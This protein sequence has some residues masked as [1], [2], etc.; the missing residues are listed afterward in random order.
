EALRELD[1][2]LN[3]LTGTIPTCIGNMVALE[4][5][6]I[7]QINVDLEG[8]LPE[9]LGD[10]V[11][12]KELQLP[13]HTFTGPIPASLGNL[14][15]LEILV[16]GG[17]QGQAGNQLE[18]PIPA[19]LSQLSNLQTLNL[20][21]NRLT[22]P[23]PT[24]L[25]NLA[26]LT[27]LWLGS[28]DLSGTIPAVLGNLPLERLNLAGNELTA[29][30]EG[31]YQGW[32]NLET[33]LLNANVLTNLPSLSGAALTFA[34][35]SYNQ[36]TFGDLEPLAGLVGQGSL[37]Y[38]PQYS[39]PL[40]QTTENGT[41]VLHHDAGGSDATTYDW[42]RRD[43][44]GSG[45]FM[46]IEG[47]T[48]PSYVVI[49][50]GEYVSNARN[51]A[52]PDLTVSGSAI[53]VEI[54]GCQQESLCVNIAEDVG[55][56][57][58]NGVP[59]L[60]DDGVCDLDP[61]TV[62]TQCSLRAALQLAK[63]SSSGKTPP[64]PVS[65]SF[66]IP[67]GLDVPTIRLTAP[68]PAIRQP[69]IIDGLTQAAGLVHLDGQ[70]L[71]AFAV[72]GIVIEKEGSG[73]TVQGLVVEGFTNGIGILLRYAS[74]NILSRNTVVGNETGIKLEGT[75]RYSNDNRESSRNRVLGN[76]LG[77]NKDQGLEIHG[78]ARENLV[79]G[80]FIG[81]ERDGG[82]PLGNDSGA[83][84]CGSLGDGQPEQTVF[85]NNVV[86]SNERWGLQLF[87]TRDNVIE[88][89]KIGTDISG[90]L[91]MP[92]RSER[93][94]VR[95]NNVFGTT[96]RDNVISGNRGNGIS[97]FFAAGNVITHNKIGTN[98]AGTASLGNHGNGIFVGEGINAYNLIGLVGSSENRIQHNV[99]AANGEFGIR[100]EK[101]FNNTILSNKIGT[102][103]T[104]LLPLG[105][106]NHGVYITAAPGT[107]ILKNVISANGASGIYLSG[108]RINATLISDNKIGSTIT[109][110]VD[111]NLLIPNRENGIT[112]DGVADVNVH[113]N[114]IAYNAGR[115]ID[116]H[117]S[118]ENNII[119][120]VIIQNL[121]AGIFAELG[122]QNVIRNND[123]RANGQGTGIHL[124]A[125]QAF[126]ES[127]TL[128]DDAGDAITLEQ[129]S[130]ASITNNNLFGNAGMGLNNL[131]PS[132]LITATDNWWGDASGPSGEG[133]GSGNGVSTGVDFSEWR[134]DMIAVVVA[135]ENEEM[136]LPTGEADT[137]SVFVQNWQVRNDV[138]DLII[139]DTEGWLQ[140]PTS[141][142][143]TLDDS[144]GAEVRLAVAVPP[145]TSN[146]TT[147]TVEVTATSQ[148][149]ADHVATTTFTLVAESAAL[150]Q[151]V[152]LPDAIE[153]VTEDTVVFAALGLDQFGRTVEI[154][155]TW[156][157][158][159][160]EID[161][162]GVY[163]AGSTMGE[164]V[165]TAT[166]PATGL[167]AT[168]RVGNG[169]PVAVEEKTNVPTD[170]H[171][172]PNYPNP[173]NPETTIA[174]TLPQQEHIR[175]IIYNVL[176]REVAV[177]VDGVQPAGTHQAPFDARGFASGIYFYRMTT[178]HFSQ[179]RTMV[180]LR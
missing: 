22:G 77:A 134:G 129:G 141:L 4:K 58:E 155:P 164:F 121:K 171:L 42:R 144:T 15:N 67:A 123:L 10:L 53:E 87:L 52:F 112:L 132:V 111:E 101:S 40:R 65:I 149:N 167:F 99:I 50:S 18:G 116:L 125:S 38:A 31:A 115:G 175:L 71:G 156:S 32:G 3:K 90:E 176:G 109:G 169:V 30:E 95:L 92:N 124:T 69:V 25:G 139:A 108:E 83:C 142:T 59:Q 110:D 138:L 23:I 21:S 82:T 84:I 178:A 177:L 2:D 49:E 37:Q 81:V 119:S 44:G 35:V 80:N 6:S 24:S 76:V 158:T 137:V 14:A 41:T 43:L 179:T 163:V 34:N 33:L 55:F 133:P 104:G 61:E 151:V 96:L 13:G 73:S 154:A 62:G 68:L 172:A 161:E 28:N 93:D 56:P 145:G 117:D 79:D 70:E 7:R 157:A 45:V 78:W 128:T 126:I 60:P 91:D 63:A 86:A 1:L 94:A 166:D 47:A 27:V 106:G 8:T 150:A 100:V 127:N 16:L 85:T 19:S 122:E 89:N 147:S 136:L 143:T 48:G 103:I 105:N 131:T 54:V 114:F 160:G 146:G 180:L 170:F 130:T 88:A 120:N 5:L 72:D 102:D 148:A 165:V 66:D 113:G 168:A 98:A 135:A 140:G 159:G 118:R 20:Q 29:F 17:S 173:F 36:L 162:N 153:V 74:D 97:L 152:V 26:N 57:V 9:S 11:N 12:L 51:S 174:Y 64:V 107:S 39:V 46:I 75:G